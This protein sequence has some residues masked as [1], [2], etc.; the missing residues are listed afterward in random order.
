MSA[1]SI[2]LPPVR[3]GW[4]VVFRR[5]NGT[6]FLASTGTGISRAVWSRRNCA[7]EFLNESLKYDL[8]GR[9]VRVAYMDPVVMTKP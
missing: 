6:E 9:V 5:D 4:S 8:R 1:P 3:R 2:K 7:R